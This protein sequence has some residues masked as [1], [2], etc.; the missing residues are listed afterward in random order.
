MA[1]MAATGS[2]PGRLDLLGGV[3]D[4]SGSLVLQ[5]ATSSLR[6]T[7]TLAL[8]P[9]LEA[10]GQPC[11]RLS[12]TAFSSEGSPAAA[13]CAVPLAPLADSDA[14]LPKVRD[15]LRSM[16]APPW[17]FYIY[18]SIAAFVFN[19][20]WKIPAGHDLEVS[21]TGNVPC[22]QGVSSSASV[23]CAV[24]RGMADLAAVSLPRPSLLQLAHWGQKAENLVVGAPC[25][26]MD[27]LACIFGAKGQVLPILCRPDSCE[28]LV[29]LPPSVVIVGWPSGVTHNVGASPYLVARTATFMGKTMAERLLG[30]SLAFAT[31]VTPSELRRRVLPSLKPTISGAEFLATYGDLSDSL[32]VVDPARLYNVSA[33]LAFPVEENHRCSVVLSLLKAMQ[34]VGKDCDDPF[35]RRCLDQIGEM[36]MQSHAGYS[37][38]GLGSPETDIIVDKL[39]Q[40]GS[41]KGIY[42][43]RVSGGGS[44]GTVVVLCERN[45]LPLV[46]SL[47]EE[48][49]FNSIPF[50]KLIV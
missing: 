37:S 28:E 32:S 19:T 40:A 44:G 27:Q 33:S 47:A 7:A 9:V 45:A 22:G 46:Q 14:D 15:F 11:A 24:L 31:E 10:G 25:G 21:V 17:A 18:G 48:T 5:V 39:A 4:Y 3:A 30:R 13:T 29:S 50:T 43:A 26:L 6:T 41:D 20:G 34:R 35:V 38:I 42:G 49:V 12:T 23:E 36:M 16:S 8:R 2:A 1:S